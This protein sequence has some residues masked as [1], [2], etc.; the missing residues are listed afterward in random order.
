MRLTDKQLRERYIKELEDELLSLKMIFYFGIALIGEMVGFF[1]IGFFG[2][3]ESSFFS[4]ISEVIFILI[5][6]V[7][8]IH[9]RKSFN[10]NNKLIGD[11]L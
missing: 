11:N 5:G 3:I 4:I 6:I 9:S 8:I 7:M 1:I 10:R 2:I